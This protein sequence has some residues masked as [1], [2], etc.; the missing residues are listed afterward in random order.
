MTIRKL[1]LEEWFLNYQ[2][3]QIQKNHFHFPIELD[4]DL[5]RLNREYKKRNQSLPI[6][7]VLIKAVG[8]LA[9][10]YPVINRMYFKTLFGER[11]VQFPYVSV[12]LPLLIQSSEQKHLSAITIA[13]ADQL[14][15]SEIRNL[16]SEGRSRPLETLP[17]LR[18]VIKSR[19]HFMNRWILKRIHDLVFR[20][21]ALY[22]KKKG[23]GISVSSLMNISDK[24]GSTR[25]YSFG[26]TAL[27]VCAS[28]ALPGPD[29]QL[30]LKIGMGFDHYALSGHE[31]VEAIAGLGKILACE[32]PE[33][34]D[35]FLPERGS[36][37]YSFAEP[38]V[39]A[40]VGS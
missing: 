7:A 1:S 13:N 32:T 34:L 16:I 28:S 21:P 30:T 38:A 33:L 25:P 39:D 4:A 14:S 35:E 31:A 40:T 18:R 15:I 37:I 2:L 6:T 5:T 26:S 8:L 36:F 23:G 24:N 27:T 3:S 22:L 10:R 29:H 9:N 19:N 17:I 12:N 20:F 11:L